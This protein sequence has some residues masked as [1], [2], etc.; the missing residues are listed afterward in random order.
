[1]TEKVGTR[2]NGFELK[3]GRFRLDIWKKNLHHESGEALEHAAQRNCKWPIPGSIQGWTGWALNNLLWLA[4][5]T[6]HGKEFGARW[7]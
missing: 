3:E 7:S 4:R 1:M 2:R 5:A 6:F